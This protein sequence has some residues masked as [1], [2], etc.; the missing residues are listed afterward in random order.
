MCH[1]NVGHLKR[2][3]LNWPDAEERLIVA[4]QICSKYGQSKSVGY[5]EDTLFPLCFCPRTN[6]CGD[7]FGHK[8]GFSISFI[9]ASEENTCIRHMN[10]GYPGCTHDDRI[11]SNSKLQKNI[12]KYFSFKEHFLLDLPFTPAYNFIP[13]HKKLREL[14]L[15]EEQHQLNFISKRP[16]SR[17][18]N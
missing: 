5:L 7:Y 12:S 11:L 18:E 10:A 14:D 17:S 4:Q 8:L 16:R 2:Q 1:S 6:D 15:N 3:C 13:A 9:I